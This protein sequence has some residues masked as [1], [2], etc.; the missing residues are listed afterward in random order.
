[1]TAVEIKRNYYRVYREKNRERIKEVNKQWRENNKE[2]LKRY[3]QNYWNKKALE[4]L[5]NE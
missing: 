1:M 2:K 5:E 4:V 3:N